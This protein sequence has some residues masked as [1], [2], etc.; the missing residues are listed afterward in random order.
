VIRAIS[1]GSG[2]PKKALASRLLMTERA[3]RNRHTSIYQKPGVAK[4][5]DLYIWAIKHPLD[6]VPD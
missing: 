2:A 1:E 5:L 6:A 4:R 3:F